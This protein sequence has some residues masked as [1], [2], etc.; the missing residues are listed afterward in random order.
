V[1]NDLAAVHFIKNKT[2]LIISP[3]F[4]GTMFLS[5]HHY[6]MELAKNDNTVYFLNP[7]YLAHD[8]KKSKK[9]VS[10]ERMDS[11]VNLFL[12]YHRI[13][14]PYFLKFHFISLFHLLI[15]YHIKKILR[16]IGHIDIVWSFDLGNLY[17]FHFFPKTALRIFHPVD[18][19]LSQSALD[20]AIGANIIF[21]VTNEILSKYSSFDV[22]KYHIQHGISES[23]LKENVGI[24]QNSSIRVGIS[25]NL[26]RPDIDRPVL[27]QIIRENPQ[28]IFECWGSYLANDSNIGAADS[29]ETRIFIMA[30]KNFQNVRLHGAIASSALASEF[31]RMDAFL[32]CYDVQKDQSRGTNYHKVMEYLSTGKVIVSNNITL[33]KDRPDLV[34][35]VMER[36]NNVQLPALFSGVISHLDRYNSND[37]IRC[38]KSFASENTYT[39]QIERIEKFLTDLKQELVV[40]KSI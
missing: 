33:Y 5:K 13:L 12:I 18:E 17:P 2:I 10:I 22:P 21:S 37:L 30:L 1:A 23:F 24:R 16:Q 32:I 15:E 26:L 31:Q 39:K 29:E 19:P 28:V 9:T 14:I 11:S 35:M 25:G 4:W 8:K 40:A 7:P 3:Q 20:A 6:A 27:L 36:N 34:C 38:R